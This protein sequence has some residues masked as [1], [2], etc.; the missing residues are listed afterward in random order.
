MQVVHERC[1]GVDVHKRT[2]VVTILV[3]VGQ[4]APEKGVVQKQTR[5]FGTMTADLLALSEWFEALG[6]THVAMEST[7]VYWWPVYNLLEEGRT[8]LLVNPRHIKAVPGRKTDVKDSEWLADLLRHGLLRPSFIPPQPI[9]A[10]RELTRYRKTLVRERTAQTNRL[11]KVLEAA[12]IKLA[13]VAT[14]VLGKSP[15]EMLEALLA[16]EQEVA[17]LAE[18]AR[19]RLRAKIPA[20]KQALQGH[21]QPQHRFLLRAILAHIDFLDAAIATTC[22]EIE[23]HLAPSQEVQEAIRL[24]Q[25]LPGIHQTAAA[26]IVAEIGVDMSCFPSAKHLASWS[27]L[28][29]GNKQSGGKRLREGITAGNPWLRGILGEVVWAISHTRDNYL[30]A[31]FRRLA[32]RRGVHKAAVALAHSVLVIIYHMLRDHKPYRDLGADYFDRIDTARLQR[33]HVRRLEQ[34]GYTVTLTPSQVA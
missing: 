25:T 12:N 4:D 3:P 16:G 8:I 34:L 19:G 27:G 24:L 22:A 5:T 30:V 15:R 31:H 23:H 14:N 13:S 21:L 1:A 7:G 2:V 32:K 18:Q 17:V 11:H 33:H 26:A 28:C 6:V 10:L 29:P 20:L 9:R